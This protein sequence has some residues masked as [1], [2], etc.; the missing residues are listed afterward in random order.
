MDRR[1]HG[2]IPRSL[3]LG[4]R[5]GPAFSRARSS[6]DQHIGIALVLVAIQP[7]LEMLGQDK[8]LPWVLFVPVPFGGLEYVSPLGRAVF[9]PSA[10][11]L[12]AGGNRQRDDSISCGEQKQASNG[13]FRPVKGKRAVHGFG[14]PGQQF[15]KI[16]PGA[17][18]SGCQ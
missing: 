13:I 2:A 8:V 15:H 17:P 10:A 9:G 12:P 4:N 6:D 11:V 3:T 16:C 5:I 7:H 18:A 14:K 1:L